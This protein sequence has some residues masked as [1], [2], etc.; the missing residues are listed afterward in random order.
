[1][2][3]INTFNEFTASLPPCFFLSQ[4]KKNT[5]LEEIKDVKNNNNYQDSDLIESI[6]DQ[7][8]LT[9]KTNF[10]IPLRNSVQLL[11]EFISTQDP[12]NSISSKNFL[13]LGNLEEAR[14]LFLKSNPNDKDYYNN[15]VLAAIYNTPSD[16]AQ[17]IVN[18]FLSNDL[19]DEAVNVLLMTNEIFPAADILSKNG[20]NEDA[21]RVLMLNDRKKYCA[22]SEKIILKVADSL[23]NN[24]EN[25]LFGLKLLASFGY[26]HEMI[27]Q[28]SLTI[29]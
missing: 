12:F 24:K 11:N 22:N 6:S 5:F 27:N 25:V 19:I 1:M 18:N 28:L 17:L 2:A 23:I 26:F 4:E 21:Y 3:V 20:R 8:F 9:D 14:N 29:A 13:K 15:M 10:S 16:S 7:I